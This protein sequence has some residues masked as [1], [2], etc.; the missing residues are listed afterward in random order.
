MTVA[1]AVSRLY[2]FGKVQA[3]D[4]DLIRAVDDIAAA[5]DP[6]DAA[7]SGNE[8]AAKVFFT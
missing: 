5:G 2:C 1:I 8:A 4:D 7:R 6:L 3:T